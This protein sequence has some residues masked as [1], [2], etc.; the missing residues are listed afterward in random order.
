MPVQTVSPGSPQRI[1]LYRAESGETMETVGPTGTKQHAWKRHRRADYA[2]L[3]EQGCD[4]P[5]YVKVG[6]DEQPSR[7]TDYVRGESRQRS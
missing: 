4:R 2:A 7:A 5:A 1:Q 6:A 3:S